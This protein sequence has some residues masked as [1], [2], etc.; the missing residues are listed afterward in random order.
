MREVCTLLREAPRG[1]CETPACPVPGLVLG[2]RV[3]SLGLKVWLSGLSVKVS[4]FEG[5]EGSRFHNAYLR[6]TWGF[7]GTIKE[8]IKGFCGLGFSV[9]SLSGLE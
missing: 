1:V 3:Q 6:T 8:T 7:A 4:G 9:C 5:F 2:L